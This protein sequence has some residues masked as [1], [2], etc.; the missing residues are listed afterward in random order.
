MMQMRLVSF[1]IFLLWSI[2]SFGQITAD[3]K[4]GYVYTS[5][6]EALPQGNRVYHLDL[7]G[8]DLTE[9]P[10]VLYRFPNLKHLDLSDNQLSALGDFDFGYF[11]N[12]ESVNLYGNRFTRFPE[13]LFS[14]RQLEELDLGNNELQEL[15]ANLGKLKFL[16][17]LKLHH[18]RIRTIRGD[19]KLAFLRH[20]RL[21]GN[22]IRHISDTL[23]TAQPR[24]EKCNLNGNQ[25]TQL[26]AAIASARLEELDIGNNAIDNS[27]IL[28]QV[29][30]L[31][32]LILDWNTISTATIDSL[33]NLRNLHTLSLEHCRLQEL[34]P[35]IGNLKSLEMLSLIG[36]P[37]ASLPQTI[38]RLSNLRKLWLTNT[39]I[40]KQALQRPR[41]PADVDIFW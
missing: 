26:P 35:S 6:E 5:L 8:K 27:H 23:F 25:L 40:S 16:T 18:N 31:E 24:L 21:D 17:V 20:L 22:R 30:S 14:A 32:R 13:A 28:F 38:Y 29:T 11:R 2:Y 4:E 19:W 15:P 41:L 33:A 34:P 10:E 39:E 1:G 9:L 36:N 12:L 7:H 37:L 3:S